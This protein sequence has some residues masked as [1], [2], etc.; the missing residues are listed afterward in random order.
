[1]TSYTLNTLDYTLKDNGI[2]MTCAVLAGNASGFSYCIET[3]DTNNEIHLWFS[4]NTNLTE[5]VYTSGSIWSAFLPSDKMAELV[6]FL[7]IPDRR[8]SL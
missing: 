7:R 8:P 1:M 6:T 5:D 4:K 3:L 2:S